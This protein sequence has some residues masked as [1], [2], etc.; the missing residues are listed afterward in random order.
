MKNIL[1][2]LWLITVIGIWAYLYYSNGENKIVLTK[3][4][5]NCIEYNEII[6]YEN[7]TKIIIPE[8]ITYKKQI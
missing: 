1:S 8:C 2:F 6:K 3:T 7:K 4:Y 5:W